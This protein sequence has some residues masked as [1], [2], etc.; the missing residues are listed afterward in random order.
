[1]V[2]SLHICGQVNQQLN[3][4]V[5]VKRIVQREVLGGA[6]HAHINHWLQSAG[7]KGPWRLY[8]SIVVEQDA[9]VVVHARILT[10]K[11]SADSEADP[12]DEVSS[13]QNP[14]ILGLSLVP[15][16]GRADHNRYLQAN[17]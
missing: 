2:V 15:R 4:V 6:V 7:D 11:M 17:E 8:R 3:L 14:V 16:H 13:P 12:R 5:K 9:E 10:L 1:M